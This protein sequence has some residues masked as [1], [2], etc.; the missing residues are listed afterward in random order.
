MIEGSKVKG[1]P[2]QASLLLSIASR[3]VYFEKIEFP[4]V[5]SSFE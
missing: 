5:L 2:K 3:V 4:G 1:S